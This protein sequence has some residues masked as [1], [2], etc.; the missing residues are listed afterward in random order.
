MLP[1]PPQSSPANLSPNEKEKKRGS[2]ANRVRRMPIHLLQHCVITNKRCISPVFCCVIIW[3]SFKTINH[4]VLH[5]LHWSFVNAQAEY[6]VLNTYGSCHFPLVLFAVYIYSKCRI[7]MYIFQLINRYIYM[8]IL[9][10]SCISHTFTM[11]HWSGG[12]TVCFPSQGCNPHFGTG[13][14]C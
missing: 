2:A 8:Y 3:F 5:H 14:T 1:P 9:W 6:P 12:L 7:Y 11:S 13:I 10:S 4:V